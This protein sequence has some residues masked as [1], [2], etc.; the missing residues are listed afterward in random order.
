MKLT[1]S[2]RQSISALIHIL[3]WGLLGF[4]LLVFQPMTSEVSF[5]LQFWVKQGILFVLLITAFYL[6]ARM[7]VPRLLFKNRNS[8]FF[9]ANLAT[10]AVLLLCILLVE[11]GLEI[12]LRMHQLF[13]PEADPATISPYPP[14]KI[15]V[16]VFVTTLLLLLISTSITVIQKWQKDEQIRQRLEKEKVQSELSFLKAQINP[17]FFFNTL[18]NIYALTLLNVDLARK[19]LH[20]LSRMMR[21]VLYETQRDTTSLSKELT[22]LQDYIELMKLRLN[23]KVKVSF[24]PP[25][26]AKDVM[27]APMLFLPFVE[28]AFKH[29]VSVQSPSCI[30]IKLCQQDHTLHLEVKNTIFKTKS[31]L[32]DE[33]SGIGLTNTRRRLD[34]LYPG[35]YALLVEQQEEDNTFLVQLKLNV[36]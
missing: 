26:S 36:S 1:L 19:A 9:L 5:P 16:G 30:S 31:A 4:V 12:P 25:A 6:N 18:N 35:K 34:L 8:L 2:F 28:N 22:F 21:Y 24:E 20:T 14:V 27:V 7:W 29:G 3:V 15:M 23:D 13:H 10:A 17:H 33:E 11:V 32:A